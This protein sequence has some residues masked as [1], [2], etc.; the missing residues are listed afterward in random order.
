VH[1]IG[2]DLELKL[3]RSDSLRVK[4]YVDVSGLVSES[5]S[6]TGAA[7]GTLVR[8]NITGRRTHVIRFRLE[9]RLSQPQFI[10][11]YF[12]MTYN[13]YRW[14]FPVADPGER[15]VVTKLEFLELMKNNP[16]RWGIYCEFIYRM[17]R[18]VT[19][20]AAYEDSNWLGDVAPTVRFSGKNLTL[21]TQFRD[22]YLPGMRK[23]LDF[24]IAYHL[25]NF[26]K[27][28]PILSKDQ[29]N[30]YL[31]ASI[32]MKVWRYLSVDASIRKALAL[33]QAEGTESSSSVDGVLGMVLRYEL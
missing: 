16:S 26:E 28:S 27:F 6:G 1:A 32:S 13:L 22:F 11:S 33:T 9:A 4:S 25:R 31:Y 17:H 24:Y 29:A 18:R 30:E 7:I 2:L 21:M 10:P 23:P 20:L 14:R 15:N 8:A 3:Y 5:S 19:V 12:D